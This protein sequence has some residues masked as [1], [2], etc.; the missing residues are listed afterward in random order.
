MP[1]SVILDSAAPAA[2]DVPLFPSQ[3]A[4]VVQFSR[5]AGQE[6]CG[7]YCG[8]VEHVVSGRSL[9]FATRAELIDFMNQVLDLG[10]PQEQRT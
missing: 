2:P 3:R 10:P 5:D 8:R 7:P 9:R 6:G 1:Q 4:F